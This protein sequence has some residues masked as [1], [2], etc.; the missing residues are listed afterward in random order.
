[1]TNNEPKVGQVDLLDGEMITEESVAE[2][3]EKL[4]FERNALILAHNYQPPIIQEIAD[5]VGDSLGLARKAAQTD[6]RVVVFCGVHFMAETA[7]ILSPDKIVLLPDL[8][9]GCPLADMADADSVLRLKEENPDAVVVSYV[10][11][12]ASVKAVSDYCCTSANAAKIVSAID[13]RRVIFVPDRNLASYVSKIVEK[14]I[15]PFP[16]FCPVHEEIS[17]AQIEQVLE[18]HPYAEVI[19][20]PECTPEVINMAHHV[21]STSGMVEVALSSRADEFVVATEEGMLY[22]LEKNVYRKR[23]FAPAGEHICANMKKITL[24]KVLTALQTLEPRVVVPDE[25]RLKALG[26]VERM[27]ELG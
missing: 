16:G 7:Y 3:I 6:V 24:T 2:E 15:I 11:T 14:E 9:A 20:H 4:K 21:R 18:E 5:Y 10:N 27:L 26:A 22:P 12:T 13:S 23:F 1:M 17:P 8:E 25:T 19:A